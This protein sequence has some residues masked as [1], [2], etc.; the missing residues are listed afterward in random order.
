MLNYQISDRW[1][2]E[3]IRSCSWLAGQTFNK[4]FDPFP[5]NLNYYPTSRN[6]NRSTKLSLE[7]QTHIKLRELGITSSSDNNNDNIIGTYRIIFHRLQKQLNPLE[8]DDTYDKRMKEEFPPSWDRSI[9]LNHEADGR[10]T[11][12]IPPNPHMQQTKVCTIL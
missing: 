6:E 8:R 9:S 2:M 1:S 12:Y 5:T 11:K 3:K 4:E 10:K 7:E